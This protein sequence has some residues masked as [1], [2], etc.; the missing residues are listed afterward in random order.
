MVVI[1]DSAAFPHIID[2]IWDGF[3][4]ETVLLARQVSRD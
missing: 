4:I 3:D 2:E 1:I